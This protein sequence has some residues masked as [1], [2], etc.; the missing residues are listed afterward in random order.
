[1]LLLLVCLL[2]FPQALAAF[3]PGLYSLETAWQS[4]QALVADF[5]A[6]LIEMRD[7]LPAS[8][9]A[10][11]SSLRDAQLRIGLQRQGDD[12]AWTMAFSHQQAPLLQLKGHQIG[13]PDALPLLMPSEALTGEL[14]KLF[15]LLSPYEQH[16]RISQ[17]IRNVGTGRQRLEYKLSQEQW[18]ALWPTMQPGLTEALTKQLSGHPA[19]AESIGSYLK[20]MRFESTGTLRRILDQEGEPLGLQL[21]ATV[22][23]A[24][25]DVRRLSLLMGYRAD[26]GLHLSLKAP[27]QKGRNQ[28]TLELSLK[29]G[30]KGK[31]RSLDGTG[32]YVYR[33]GQ[34]SAQYR[35]TVKLQSEDGEGGGQ[36]QSWELKPALVFQR[37]EAAG[38]LLITAMQGQRTQLRL[39][40]MLALAPVEGLPAYSQGDALHLDAADPASLA[41]AGQALQGSLLPRLEELLRSLPEAQRRGLWHDIGREGRTIGESVPALD[42]PDEADNQFLVNDG[43]SEEETP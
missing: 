21:T 22:S 27:A 37:G 8:L 42:L 2:V 1:M 18:N 33:H 43:S 40:L 17:S 12:E 20:A 11:Q 38:D 7:M 39:K 35:L 5:K 32:S 10:L 36:R 28:L 25:E 31:R 9:T 19:W 29:Q 6:E 34:D 14:N 3:S 24:G 13:G 26:T 23:K 30:V 16:S 4:G 15:A 41:A